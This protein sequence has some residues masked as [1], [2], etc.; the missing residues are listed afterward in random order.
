[1]TL[2]Q[3]RVS[4]LALSL[5]Y[6]H[7]VEEKDS[8]NEERYRRDLQALLESRAAGHA[9]YGDPESFRNEW[10]GRDEWYL[11]LFQDETLLDPTDGEYS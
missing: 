5:F 10:S 3:P 11:G 7:A 1:M 9:R 4:A 6:E 8:A 2:G